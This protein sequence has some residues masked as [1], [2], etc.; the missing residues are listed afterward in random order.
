MADD[1]NY[2]K[3]RRMIMVSAIIGLV[4]G[5]AAGV[6]GTFMFVKAGNP[7]YGMLT[8]SLGLPA[9]LLVGA[10]IGNSLSKNLK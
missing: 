7:Q 4:V 6:F 5:T 1:K 9:G 3:K 10:L 8:L 2:E